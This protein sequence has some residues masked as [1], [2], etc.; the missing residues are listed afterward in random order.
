MKKFRHINMNAK[1]TVVGSSSGGNGYLL[2]CND[3]SLI[4]ECGMPAKEMVKLLGLDIKSVRGCLVTHQHLDHVGLLKQY[5][6]YFP[7]NVYSCPSVAEENSKVNALKQKMR[8]TIGGFKVIP[9]SVPHGDCE[10]YAYHITLPDGQTLL[11]ATDLED[12]PYSIKG[13]NHLFIECNYSEDLIVDRLCDGKDVRSLF[14]T[15]MELSKC[16][17]VIK[18]LQSPE[19]R[20]VVLLHLSDANSDEKQFKQCVWNEC[21]IRCD[22]ADAGKVYELIKDDF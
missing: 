9:L 4:I 10:C 19:M 1:I 2:Q 8:Y 6:R 3:E 13:I 22:C 12:F 18:R 17:D 20:S 11:F 14:D 7:F 21:G 16:I 15:H 5:L